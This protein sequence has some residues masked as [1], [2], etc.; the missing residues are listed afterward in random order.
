MAVT[1][2]TAVATATVETA[3]AVVVTGMSAVTVMTVATV[4]AVVIDATGISQEELAARDLG[5][6]RRW[7]ASQDGDMFNEKVRRVAACSG[8]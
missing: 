2:G 4:V 8:M 1:A 6:I 7:Y 3:E 5:A